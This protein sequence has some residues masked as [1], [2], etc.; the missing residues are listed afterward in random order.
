MSDGKRKREND[1]GSVSNASGGAGVIPGSVS[2][3]S[4]GA[5]VIPAL[6]ETFFASGG[7]G[8]SAGAGGDPM[9]GASGGAGD[10]QM[11]QC[12]D[13]ERAEVYKNWTILQTLSAEDIA[14]LV[15]HTRVEFSNDL[16][17]EYN[18]RKFD[19]A[20]IADV[21]TLKS[22]V[23]CW[24]K[25][26]HGLA[27]EG[28]E[29]TCERVVFLIH[30]GG[31][32][33]GTLR[34]LVWNNDNPKKVTEILFNI[35]AYLSQKTRSQVKND[36]NFYVTN[37]HSCTCARNNGKKD[38]G[39]CKP[40]RAGRQG[41]HCPCDG[42]CT[43]TCYSVG[44]SLLLQENLVQKVTGILGKDP[45]TEQPQQGAQ[46][47]SMMAHTVQLF[48]PAPSVPS[49]PQL[50]PG[51][52]L[53]STISSAPTEPPV[54]KSSQGSLVTTGES[55]DLSVSR[56]SSESPPDFEPNFATG[57]V[58]LS[59]SLVEAANAFTSEDVSSESS[60]RVV[61]SESSVRVV[62]SESSDLR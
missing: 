44:G 46:Q 28:D 62:S 12:P 26:H 58:E 9:L 23:T 55:L 4:G 57:P 1:Q 3:A 40:Q 27:I 41:R 54:S 47:T 29:E 52:F 38:P 61:S 36:K 50:P 43:W 31:K 45:W 7:A 18:E 5:G 56:S 19:K 2:N 25:T 35:A 59:K 42:V 14:N 8:A 49:S 30:R 6:F 11:R 16:D 51:S 15:P 37:L 53:E 20:Q 60:V 34:E 48:V 21:K 32:K 13:T 10:S 33:V 22:A 24:N 17:K 39:Q